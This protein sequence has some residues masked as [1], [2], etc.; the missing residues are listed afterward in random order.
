VKALVQVGDLRTEGH[1]AVLGYP[2][3]IVP[4]DNPYRLRRGGTLRARLLVDGAP[5]PHG[6]VLYGGTTARGRRIAEL[7][8]RS[9]SAGVVRIR[10]TSPGVWYLKFIHMTRLP[11]NPDG[12]THESK[13]ATL[14][15]G[16]R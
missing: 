13:W 11:A 12:L 2:A 1:A 4:L 3:E 6:Y 16:A 7:A 10:V 5:V 15:F 9:D 14:T 8:S